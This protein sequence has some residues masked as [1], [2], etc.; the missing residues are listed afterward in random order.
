MDI[1][2][3]FEVLGILFAENNNVEIK[4]MKIEKNQKEAS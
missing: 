3:F 4:T 1:E 2:K